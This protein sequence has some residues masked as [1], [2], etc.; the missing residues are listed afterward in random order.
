MK[1]TH[2]DF[3]KENNLIVKGIN[4]KGREISTYIAI[5]PTEYP[6]VD[7]ISTITVEPGYEFDCG[8]DIIVIM[9]SKSGNEFLWIPPGIRHFE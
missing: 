2:I 7:V 9:V 6:R 8:D 1:I 4:E 3:N 5:P